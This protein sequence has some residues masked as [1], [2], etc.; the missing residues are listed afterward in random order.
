MNRNDPAPV[1]L[2]QPAH[3]RFLESRFHFKEMQS[4]ELTLIYTDRG[5]AIDL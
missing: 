2:V 5:G 1:H 4:H 3:A